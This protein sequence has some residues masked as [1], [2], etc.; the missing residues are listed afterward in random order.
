MAGAQGSQAVPPNVRNKVIANDGL[1][2]LNCASPKLRTSIVSEPALE[3]VCNR[4]ALSDEV[5]LPSVL[6]DPEFTLSPFGTPPESIIALAR[7]A[8]DS[9]P[10]P[11]RL[12]CRQLWTVIN[13]DGKAIGRALD[14]TPATTL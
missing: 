12:S 5:R 11:S 3:K 10:A 8:L 14:D 9:Y 4:R 6:L 2:T 7:Q 1:V 13:D